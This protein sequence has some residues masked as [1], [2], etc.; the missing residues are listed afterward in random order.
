MKILYILSDSGIGGAAKS[1]IEFLV[2]VKKRIDPIVIIPGRGKAEKIIK[3]L[4]IEYYVVPFSRDCG[5]SDLIDYDSIRKIYID[6][7][8]AAL[9]ISEI[10]LQKNVDIVH[11]NSSTSNVGAMAAC[12]ASKPHVWHIREL[13]E[14]HYSLFYFDELLK[15]CL[16]N[17]ASAVIS[18]SD[19]VK[20]RI[21]YKYGINSIR[22]YNGLDL[23]NYYEPLSERKENI[24]LFAGAICWEKGQFD[25]IKAVKELVD[26]GIRNAKLYLVGEGNSEIIWC[27][28]KYI[29]QF[30]LED[31]VDIYGYLDNFKELRKVAKISI[32]G[33]KMEA[34]GRTTIEAMLA[35]TNVIGTD[36]GGNIELIKDGETGWMYR[37]GDCDGL[38]DKLELIFSLDESYRMDV[39]KQAQKFALKNFALDEYVNSMMG[40]YETVLGSVVNIKELKW[41][42]DNKYKNYAKEK[43]TKEN[44]TQTTTISGISYS[45]VWNILL[46]NFDCIQVEFLKTGKKDIIIYGMGNFGRKL[47]DKLE[48]SKIRIKYVSDRNWEKINEFLPFYQAIYAKEEDTILVV[49]ENEEANIVRQFKKRYSCNVIGF[50]EIIYNYI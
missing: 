23:A 7:Y 44:Q 25:A 15:E 38:A 12:F 45:Q 31:Y 46:N 32:N 28:N 34:L 36:S 27:M 2:H 43:T 1:L 35:G 41:Y 29:K 47:Y 30:N 18:I 33:S 49:V 4:S 21:D 11:T 24:I 37:F 42:L 20:D 8:E 6:N 48:N 9:K 16:L 5:T 3:Q 13:I 17:S 22:I 26:R 19:C 40:I 39:A 10:V 14:E 50:S